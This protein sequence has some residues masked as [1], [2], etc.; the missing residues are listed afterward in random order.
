MLDLQAIDVYYGSSQVISG[1]SLRV[2][3][4]EP[5]C[6][7][8][9]NGVG[10]STLLRS[11]IGLTP[12]KSGSIVLDGE[13]LA[14]LPP[15]V[16]ARKGIAYVPQGQQLFP[17]L[18]VAENL[19]L[20]VRRRDVL[21]ERRE[22]AFQYFPALQGRW[23]HRA[24]TLSGGQQKFLALARGLIVRPRLLLLDEPS[25]GIQPNVVLELARTIRA[26]VA[27]RKCLLLLVE[28]NR[29]LAFRVADRAYVMD[30]GR[31]VAEGV[32][33]ELESKGVISRYM[34]F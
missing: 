25:E 14:G 20:A 13:N 27:D 11:I 29:T 8:G 10:K 24:G 23:N 9:K 2:A 4:G 32:P 22:E 1:A 26:I 15:H 21:T 18:T 31:I 30:R 6:V 5:V 19:L 34:S 16:I 3:E 7:L 17:D 28:Q 33:P 12:P